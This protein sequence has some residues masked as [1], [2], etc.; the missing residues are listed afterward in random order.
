M[1]EE[2]RLLQIYEMMESPD[3]EKIRQLIEILKKEDS[4]AMR[5]A[6]VTSL[7]YLDLQPFYEEIF[8]L[9]SSEDAY[10]RNAAVE[11]F[12]AKGSDA[13]AFLTSKMDS[14]YHEVRKL[15]L[16]SLVLI[17]S[18]EAQLAVRAYIYD[19]NPNVQITAVEYVGKLQDK[20]SV[21]ELIK[22]FKQKDEPMLRSTIIQSITELESEEGC[23]EIFKYF[24]NTEIPEYL[25]PDFL[26]MVAKVGDLETILKTL[27]ILKYSTAVAKDLIDFIEET[28]NR[29]PE[30]KNNP[31][32]QDMI[33]KILNDPF[34][35]EELKEIL[36]GEEQ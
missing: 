15:I 3:Q 7:K 35:D 31:K 32:V 4:I 14:Q 19:E 24:S 5:E 23:R 8:N 29:F 2:E 9:F 34:V 6:I 17:G 22:L 18:P 1:K 25:L 36:R 30:I 26:K 16:D 12:G 21:P 11:I 28:A 27:N 20:E 10:L 33:S 13:V